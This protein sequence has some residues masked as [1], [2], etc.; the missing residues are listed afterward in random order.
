MGALRGTVTVRFDAGAGFEEL[1]VT[2]EG[3]KETA[4][5]L[6]KLGRTYAESETEP[7]KPFGLA[8]IMLEEFD[9]PCAIFRP[10]RDPTSMQKSALV[11]WVTLTTRFD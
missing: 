7:V 11:D 9:E 1:S 3:F 2:I 10:F 5:P 6:A 4:G 8:T